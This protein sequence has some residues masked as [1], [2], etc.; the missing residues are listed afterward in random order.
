MKSDTSQ[1]VVTGL[2][3]LTPLGGDVTST[4]SAMIAGRSGNRRLDDGW[5]QGLPVRIAA[6][7]VADLAEVIARSEKRRMDRSVQLV[8]A[9]A[10]QAWQHAGAPS[11]KPER[12]ATSVGV[13][14][15]SIKCLLDSHEKIKATGWRKLSPYTVPMFMPNGAAAVLS[16]E[17]NAKAGSH[18][19]CGGCA[20]GAEAIGHGMRLI[21]A[22]RA[23]VVVAGGTDA[24]ILPLNIAAFAR[25]GALSLHSDEPERACRPFDKS[26]DGFVLGE[27]AGVVILESA[28]HAA[29]RG[30]TVHAVAAGVGYA[31]DPG[32]LM[33]ADP[34]APA[35]GAAMRDALADANLSGDSVVHINANASANPDGDGTE[36]MAI[37]ATLG[38]AARGVCVSATKAM[39]GHLVGGSGAVE[40][41]ATICALRASAAPPTLNLEIPC[42][43]VSIAGIHVAPEA[44]ELMR[45]TGIRVGLSNSGGFGV[46][47]VTLAFAAA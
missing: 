34:D 44:C 25:M 3:A 40:A 19:A 5:T 21:R 35:L 2:G 6:P 42:D 47:C 31:S 26:G 33:R 17:F 13:G 12:L 1:V 36:I 38:Q 24:A 39:T 41:I 37:Q 45:K 18:T 14:L 9:A 8:L 15:G 7:V 29:R 23:D 46:Q 43:E 20:S 30:A 32:S 10:R 28:D 16:I 22:G 4:W 27:G 11:V